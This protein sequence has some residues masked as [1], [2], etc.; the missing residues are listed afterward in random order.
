[1]QVS[2]YDLMMMPEYER[3]Q[4]LA[5]RERLLGGRNPGQAGGGKRLKYN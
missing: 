3:M 2:D 4:L 1:M 5:L